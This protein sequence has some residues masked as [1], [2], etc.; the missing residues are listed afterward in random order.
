MTQPSSTHVR[1][2]VFEGSGQPV[3]SAAVEVISF[4]HDAIAPAE[5]DAEGVALIEIPDGSEVLHVLAL[6]AGVG[7]DYFENY[8]C[9][10]PNKPLPGLPADIHLVL[11]GAIDVPVQAVDSS[12]KPLPDVQLTPWT[13]RRAGKTNSVNCSGALS[14]AVRT[15]AAGWA[16]FRWMPTDLE[17]V[18]QFLVRD[19]SYHCPYTAWIDPARAVQPLTARLLRTS[20][21]SG[22]VLLPD[23]RPAE[24]LSVQAEGRGRTNFY[25]RMVAKSGPDGAYQ[26]RVYPDQSYLIGV[27]ESGRAARTLRGVVVREGQE[28]TGLDLHLIEGTRLHGRITVR[29][30][31]RPAGGQTVGI[32]ERGEV[33]ADELRGH[34]KQA[35]LVRWATTDEE[36]RYEI[37]LG[38]GRYEVRG[39]YPA[40]REDLTLGEEKE[41]IRDFHLA[42]TGRGPLAGIVRRE[43]G[44]AVGNAVVLGEGVVRGHAGFKTTA[45]AE[46][47]FASERWREAMTVYA[48][49][50][51]G[52]E[53]G[54][55]EIAAEDEHL[56]VTITPAATAKG[57]VVDGEGQPRSNESVFCRMQVVMADGT[58]VTFQ[59]EV[60]T[61]AAGTFSLPGLMVGSSCDVM[62]LR[63]HAPVGPPHEFTLERAG[64]VTVPDIVLQQT[65]IAGE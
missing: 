54:S 27:V 40:G 55:V 15:D 43:N 60:R 42:W 51:A 61:D 14:T 10:P 41:V 64:G 56:V 37:R 47:Q 16:R 23:G 28:L 21:L 58:R 17:D 30:D 7:L 5:T 57:R 65:E 31:R 22:R 25:C 18:T 32:M 12:G 8:R 20:Q 63:G 1:V 62:V 2:V 6:K 48:R 44:R 59:I 26:L 29:P 9:W 4:S 24:G 39:P 34:F 36:G 3:P 46:G 45:D 13:I 35:E 49:S 38:P 50:V 53:A 33:L 11:G 19:R 52:D